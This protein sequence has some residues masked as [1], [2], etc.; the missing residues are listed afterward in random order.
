MATRTGISEKLAY[1]L[2]SGRLEENARNYP[3]WRDDILQSESIA[4]QAIEDELT[5]HPLTHSYYSSGNLSSDAYFASHYRSRGIFP[6]SAQ[7]PT[8]TTRTF[9]IDTSLGLDAYSFF[10]HAN[11]TSVNPYGTTT[12]LVDGD[13][14]KDS[15]TVVSPGDISNL[16]TDEDI[17]YEE[18]TDKESAALEEGY[19]S[20]LVSG[21]DR[22]TLQ[23][24][25]LLQ[26]VQDDQYDFVHT[27]I[28]GI[29]GEIKY[30]GILPPEK[31]IGTLT[32]DDERRRHWEYQASNGFIAY[33]LYALSTLPDRQKLFEDACN[34]WRGVISIAR[35]G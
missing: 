1:H 9:A 28:E 23:A 8:D 14:L 26:S 7:P 2:T 25:G 35:H 6:H 33:D 12:I 29:G 11:T 3:V 30:H 15:R 20:Q 13:I 21:R 18:L 10:H 32:N 5:Q 22:L 19:F 34:F 27:S 31:I 16:I 24:L 17:P 4:I